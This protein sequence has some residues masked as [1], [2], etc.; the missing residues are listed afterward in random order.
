MP[1]GNTVTIA[2]V[3]QYL[4]KTGTITGV[5]YLDTYP[6]RP[7]K[8]SITPVIRVSVQP[9]N[10]TDLPKLIQGLQKLAKSDPLVRCYT[11]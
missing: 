5:D 10:P 1:C 8:Y 3:D 7:I 4:L 11:E 6:I 2:G 9:Q